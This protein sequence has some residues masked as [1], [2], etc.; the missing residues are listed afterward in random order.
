MNRLKSYTQFKES[1]VISS[2]DQP[3]EK[4]AKEKVNTTEEQLKEYKEKKPKIEQLYSVTKNPVEIETE[5]S[6]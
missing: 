6:D 1:M 3:D 4:L 2:T 5:L